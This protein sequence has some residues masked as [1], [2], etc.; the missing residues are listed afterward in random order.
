[1]N[2]VIGLDVAKG[3]SKVQA[4]LQRIEAYKNSF[5]FTHDLPGLRTFHVFYQE[6]EKISGQPPAVILE[7]TGHYHG[8]VLQFLADQEIA[9]YLVNPVISFEARKT[10]LR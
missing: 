7:S 9:Y 3:E 4:F 2:P 1:M 6:L 5:K 8:P 10:S